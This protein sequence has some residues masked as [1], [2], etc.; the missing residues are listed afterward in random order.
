M[1]G[2]RGSSVA[3]K[4]IGVGDVGGWG[5]SPDG[6]FSPDFLFLFCY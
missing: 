5:S 1:H 6:F 4:V 2:V 3:A